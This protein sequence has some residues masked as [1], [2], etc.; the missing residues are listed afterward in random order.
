MSYLESVNIK[1]VEVPMMCLIS[2]RKMVCEYEFAEE[3]SNCYSK[4]F[5]KIEYDKLTILAPLV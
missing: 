2:I 4:L 1:L 3:Y 5:K